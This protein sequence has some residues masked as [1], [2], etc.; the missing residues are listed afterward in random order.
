MEAAGC[1]A[2]ASTEEL[3]VRG[4]TEVIAHL[5]RLLKLRSRITQRFLAARIP[6][7][8][9]VDSPD[10]NLGLARRLK[11]RGVRTVQFVSPSV[12]AWRRERL[13]TIGRSI[14]RMLALS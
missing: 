7:F 4:F 3:A 9:G 8:I 12:W 10:F 1:E 11:R 5:P 2:W 13:Q 14:D 6:L